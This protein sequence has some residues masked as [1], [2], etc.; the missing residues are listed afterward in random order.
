MG[1]DNIIPQFA[2]SVNQATK[3]CIFNKRKEEFE[4]PEDDDLD[5]KE[6]INYPFDHNYSL[7]V[8][9]DHDTTKQVLLKHVASKDFLIK[10]NLVAFANI[11]SHWGMCKNTQY[12]KGNNLK[13]YLCF[14]E[15]EIS[16]KKQF[17]IDKEFIKLANVQHFASN[18]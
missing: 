14:I 7:D 15:K 16:G 8:D 4:I 18:L 12:W 10:E 17:K 9:K 1:Y 13:F 5:E 3:F 6:V 11:R 2:L